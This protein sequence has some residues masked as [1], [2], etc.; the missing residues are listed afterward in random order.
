[1][2]IS[3]Q[4]STL[5]LLRRLI[6][7]AD[8]SVPGY[9]PDHFTQLCDGI[10]LYAILRTVAPSTFPPTTIT[11]ITGDDGEEETAMLSLTSR[12]FESHAQ[13]R[14]ANLS[15][16]LRR[17]VQYAKEPMGQ[18]PTAAS[19]TQ[20]L[21][22][23]SL[24]E[25]AG[26]GSESVL[27]AA[28]ISAP[29]MQLVGIAVT[30]VVL[31]GVKAILGEVKSLPREDQVVLSN[32]VR[33]LMSV[34]GLK[35]RS[36][37]AAQIGASTS[38]ISSGDPTTTAGAPAASLPSAAQAHPQRAA[39][40]GPPPGIT[41]ASM[42][43]VFAATTHGSA[44]PA[45]VSTINNSQPKSTARMVLGEAEDEGYYR[46]AVYQLRNELA[47][48]KAQL[49]AMQDQYRIA[50]ED[51]DTAESKYRL[52]L[53]EQAKAPSGVAASAT[54]PQGGGSS[55]GSEHQQEMLALWQ[56]RCRNKDETIATLTARV[57]EQSAQVAA[58]KSATA[59]HEVALQA[60]RR[61]LKTAEEGVMVKSEEKR[62]AEEKLAVAEDKFAAQ[63][64]MRLELEN[65][66]EELN[67]R[68]L[69]LTLEQDRLR[70]FGSGDE[71]PPMN[72]SFV[73]NGSVDRVMMLENEL[74]EVRHQRDSLQRQVGILQRQVAAMPSPVA[75]VSTANDTWRAQLRQVERE[76]ED[77]RQQLT[78]A[79]ERN[80]N[81]QQELAARTT[82][83]ATAAVANLSLSGSGVDTGE[84]VDASNT[85]GAG[86]AHTAGVTD[87]NEMDAS[88][89]SV[90]VPL[91]WADN[92]GKKRE[93]ER[94]EQVILSSLLMQ[95]SYRNLLLQQHQ[96]L[97]H[98]DSAEA[99]V[100]HQRQM[101]E[102]LEV[103]RQTHSP[104]LTQQRRDVE[105]GLL[106]SVLHGAKLRMMRVEQ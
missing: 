81:L 68:V 21:D 45:A 72:T 26:D 63:M 29:L 44:V 23:A 57:E 94:R 40:A 58:L 10:S 39:P 83:A 53:G 42:S 85:G 30:L 78:T 27:A 86:G 82:S 64:K 98:K 17:I 51:K 106:E 33:E 84:A 36:Q 87:S 97:L 3:R 100:A 69:V 34:Y 5:A 4:H 41:S 71:N 11:A 8:S 31:S 54:A 2:D 91:H 92:D 96:T 52:L 105:K 7:I 14:K 9:V 24:A 60:L 18:S 67:S 12:S 66:V 48:V 6:P 99:E 47:E 1:M 95:Y 90:Y 37:G 16:L 15:V 56:E 25:L 59:A 20:G 77:L 32:W 102:H 13:M 88:S 61:R 74:D 70:G 62:A 65:Q 103:A 76:R 73:S 22:A 49:S 50:K 55:S 35:P 104:L 101:E 93:A 46:N 75:D 80:G 19:I 79:L 43:D 28:T 38:G 89:S